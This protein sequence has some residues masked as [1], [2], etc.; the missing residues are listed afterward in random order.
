MRKVKHVGDSALEAVIADI[1]DRIDEVNAEVSEREPNRGVKSL[2]DRYKLQQTQWQE[3]I[4]KVMEKM[5]RKEHL[6][7]ARGKDPKV[8]YDDPRDSVM[9]HERMVQSQMRSIERQAVEKILKHRHNR[10]PPWHK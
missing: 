7:R 2:L 9:S 10:Q 1:E 5:S 3:T 4:S 6:K 8:T